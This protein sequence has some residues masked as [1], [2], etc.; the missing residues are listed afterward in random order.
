[1]VTANQCANPVPVTH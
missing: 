1:M